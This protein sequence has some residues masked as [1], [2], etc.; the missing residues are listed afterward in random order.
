MSLPRALSIDLA[1]L[2][3]FLFS[4][5][6]LIVLNDCESVLGPLRTNPQEICSFAEW[7]GWLEIVCPALCP[8]SLPFLSAMNNG[9]CPFFLLSYTSAAGDRPP[10]TTHWSNSNST[11][12]RSLCSLPLPTTT[13]GTPPIDQGTEEAASEA[14]TRTV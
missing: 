2:R 9:F 4:K 12:C 7:L 11:L 8:A 5:E 13:S 14:A 6:M 1:S 10:S 3:P